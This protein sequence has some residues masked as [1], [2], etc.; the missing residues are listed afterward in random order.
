MSTVKRVTR[1]VDTVR[2]LYVPLTMGKSRHGAAGRRVSG[3][4]MS[5]GFRAM[6]YAGRPQGG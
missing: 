5:T 2:T 4:E 3:R 6:V 1:V